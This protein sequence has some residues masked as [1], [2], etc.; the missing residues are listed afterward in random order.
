MDGFQWMTGWRSQ[1]THNAES[2][3]KKSISFHLDAVIDKK[4]SKDRFASRH[5]QQRIKTGRLGLQ[6][7]HVKRTKQPANTNLFPTNDSRLSVNLVVGN[8]CSLI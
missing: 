8:A 6:V 3:N 7:S 1:D 5:P 4:K 2:N